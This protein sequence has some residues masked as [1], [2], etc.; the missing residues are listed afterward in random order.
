MTLQELV[1]KLA[2]DSSGLDKAAGP[3]GAKLKHLEQQGAKTEKSV[4]KIGKTSKEAASGVGELT[5]GLAAFAA[6]VGT[7]TALAT[8]F[9]ETVI[10]SNAALSRLSKNLGVSVE[11]ISAWGQAVEALGGSSKGLQ[12]TL[13]MLSQSQTELSLTGQSSL[14]PYFSSLGIAM[15]GVDGK[16]RPVNAIL[17]DLS[18]R[19]EHMDRPT[20]NNIGKMIGIDQD[21]LNLLLQGRRELELTLKRQKEYNAV[22][23]AQAEESAKLQRSMI[24]LRQS[25]TA[26]GRDLLQQAA[27]ALEKL[28]GVLTSL[29]GWITRNLEFIKDLGLVLGTIAGFVGLIAAIS[30][31]FAAI[32]AGVIALGTAIALLWQDYQTW[33][34]GGQSLIPWEKWQPGILAAKTAIKDLAVIVK[35]AFGA[36]FDEISSVQE[37]LHGDWRGS[38]A[39]T[40]Q[41]VDKIRSTV[42]TGI[43]AAHH[44]VGVLHDPKSKLRG[45][46]AP[47]AVAPSAAAA[48]G[49]GVTEAQAWQQAQRVSAKT[50][51]KADVIMAQ[52]RHETGN[53]TNRGA[54]EL[55]NLSG[56]NVPGGH[57]QDYRNFKTLDEYGDY[58]ASL[59]QRKYPGVLGA[60]DTTT[61]AQGLRAGG[62]Y[63]D[64]LANYEHG[65]NASYKPDR[66]R[67]LGGIPGASSTLNGIPGASSNVAQAGRTGQST[68]NNDHSTTVTMNGNTIIQTAAT[69]AP[70]IARD[71]T[72]AL[73]WQFA[74]QANSG[75][76]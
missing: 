60:Q 17:L 70:G 30:S 27:P 74:G 57:G 6:I 4:E 49:T 40:H 66:D 45:A 46:T 67:T 8:A 38:L 29:G 23:K 19:F 52:F 10:N 31:P 2:L 58:L 32:I 43:A 37:L 33:Q 12:G 59:Y 21:T 75:L 18:E 53:F 11:D 28:L 34:R 64:S 50:G 54:R 42:M 72:N 44:E 7:A 14:I 1:V 56:V 63:T 9:A 20:A 73:K 5:K 41:T 47:P 22:T 15:A 25:F 39:A 48:A 55:N 65:L 3:A 16:A 69:D 68:T 24:G 62:Y 71:F 13:S 76:N 36:I 35:E 51:I 61:F 26:L